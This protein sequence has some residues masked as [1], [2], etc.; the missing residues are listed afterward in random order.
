LALWVSTT[1]AL[2][3]HSCGNDNINAIIVLYDYLSS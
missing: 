1:G 2:S 3:F